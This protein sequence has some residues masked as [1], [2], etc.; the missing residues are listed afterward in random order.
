MLRDFYQPVS[1]SYYLAR[2]PQC[3]PLQA[4]ENFQD[5]WPLVFWGYIFYFPCAAVAYAI[6]AVT[7]PTRTFVTMAVR[8][9]SLSVLWLVG[10]ERR[11][12]SGPSSLSA[13]LV[14][15]STSPH[16]PL[17]PS[18]RR[19]VNEWEIYVL[20]SA[21]PLPGGRSPGFTRGTRDKCRSDINLN[22]IR[23]NMR[24]LTLQL[25]DLKAWFIQSRTYF[26]N[27]PRWC[28]VMHKALASFHHLWFSWIGPDQE[29]KMKPRSAS[30][31]TNKPKRS[32]YEFM[33]TDM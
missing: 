26:L 8:G 10:G 18:S 2:R 22:P 1:K 21:R 33:W 24:V 23:G 17:F 9:R 3:P 13:G 32:H 25:L 11:S 29:T 6:A 28:A 5:N 31:T 12:T 7:R 4:V 14:K 16:P 19:K 20:L 27:Y 15:A 30:F